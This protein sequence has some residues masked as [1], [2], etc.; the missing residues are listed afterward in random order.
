IAD[1]IR[2]ARDVECVA[3][4]DLHAKRRLERTDLRVE[5]GVARTRFAMP[6]VELLDEIEL[7]PRLADRS[8]GMLQVGKKALDRQVVRVD[9]DA[10]VL[11]RK[12]AIRPEL[13]TDH[14]I[15]GR[16]D[17]EGRQVAILR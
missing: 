1:R 16:E 4:L 9:R 14:R 2:L 12:E 8:R 17:D 6:L 5:L 15:A 3:R 13:R 11:S 10:L 7:S